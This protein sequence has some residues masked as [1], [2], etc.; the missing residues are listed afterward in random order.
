MCRYNINL[1]RYFVYFSFLASLVYF[2]QYWHNIVENQIKLISM[3]VSDCSIRVVMTCTPADL[4]FG[5]LVAYIAGRFSRW[6][7]D[8]S[9][10]E[11]I[12]V[13]LTDLEH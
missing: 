5:S 3:C 2:S 4:I 1:F 11:I 10:S 13:L 7:P 8:F 12:D 6:F 9:G